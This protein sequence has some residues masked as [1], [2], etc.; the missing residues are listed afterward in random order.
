MSA[1]T[2]KPAFRAATTSR[3]TCLA[4]ATG[5]CLATATSVSA[6]LFHS[7]ATV[8]PVLVQ[9]EVAANDPE[10]VRLLAG[11]ARIESELQLGNLLLQL[12]QAD[13]ESSDFADPRA[14]TLPGIKDGLAA[15][16]VADLEPLLQALEAGG[17]AATVTANYQ[18]VIT[19]LAVAR[20]TLNP[21]NHDLLLS[22]AAQTTAAVALINASGPTEVRAY[23]DAWSMLM[24]A[25]G[26]V[27][28][29]LGDADPA[30][31][32]AA[33]EMGRDLDDVILSLPDPAV[34]EPVELD[35]APIQALEAKMEGLAGAI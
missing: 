3:V 27:D 11:L 8:K 1:K 7:T 10:T 13:A 19:G 29:L 21:S 34:T 15:A 23:Q 4:V 20:S 22:V 25:R 16:G 17:D 31:V 32:Q 28:Q 26:Q 14:E 12:G 18:K 2:Q 33:T 24:I 35:L 9:A 5:L 30:I 6:S